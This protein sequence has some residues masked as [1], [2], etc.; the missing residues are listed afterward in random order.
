MSFS[1]DTDGALTGRGGGYYQQL[2]RAGGLAGQMASCNEIAKK[3]RQLK[4]KQAAA[5]KAVVRT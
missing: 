1:V 4:T 2:R 5:T 3:W